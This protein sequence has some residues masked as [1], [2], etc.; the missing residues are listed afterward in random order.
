MKGQLYLE[1]E[2]AL[3]ISIKALSYSIFKIFYTSNYQANFSKVIVELNNKD[4][5]Q[6]NKKQTT[7]TKSI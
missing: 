4:K 1:I 3:E 6:P 2:I 7:K 5:V